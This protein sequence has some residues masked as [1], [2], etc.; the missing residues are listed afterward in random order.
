MNNSEYLNWMQKEL[1]RSKRWRS[2]GE[3][4]YE[5]SWKRFIDL[6]RG[7]HYDRKSG[8]DQL[9][10]NMIFATLNVMAPAVAIRNPKFNVNARNVDSAP[11]AIITEEVL[12][13][14][15][16][17]NHFQQDFRLS[18]NDWLTIGHGWL[19]VGYTFQKPPEEKKTEPPTDTAQD[20]DG[21]DEG[22]DD[23]EDVPGNVETEL[24]VQQ[25]DE[26]PFM[27]RISPFDMFVD[28][29]CR[30]PKEM[31]W[32]AQR[33]WRPVQ[34]VKV[35]SRYVAAARKNVSGTSRSSRD[36]GNESGGGD[37]RDSGEKPDAGAL[38]Y[39]EV[40]EFYDIKRNKVSTF[41][42]F[43]TE[44]TSKEAFL[45]KPTKMP[46]AFGHPFVMLRNYEVPDHFY[47]MGDVQQIESLQIELNETRNQMFNFRKKYRRA[48][49]YSKDLFDREGVQALESDEDNVMIPVLGDGNPS[50][51]LAPVV[52]SITPPEFFDQSAM[53]SNDIDRISGV[54]DYQ[55]G[56][57]TS[58]KRTATEA[59]M[60]QDAANARAQDRLGKVETILA[61]CGERI[62]ALMQQYVTGDQVARIVT[63]PVRGWINYNNDKIQGK[64]DFEV[65]GGSTEPQNEST[66]RQAA[67]QAVDM[68]V[69]FM[70]EGVVNTPA[71]YMK[72]LR[73]GLGFKDAER[74]V[75]MQEPQ[76]PPP[77]MDQQGQKQGMHEMPDGSMMPDSEMQQGPPQGMPPQGMPPQGGP[78]AAINPEMLAMLQQ[79]LGGQAPPVG[80]GA[81]G[82]PPELLQ[83]MM[84]AGQ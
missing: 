11:Q 16:R 77:G 1:K 53:I 27:E 83:Q 67:L 64:F 56:A 61:Q 12:N 34:D 62:V 40:I 47:P 48:H 26:R 39:V 4:N 21:A 50:S 25:D 57:Q 75:K 82:I 5:R 46:Y 68:S 24:I 6:Y 32:V 84:Q 10:V 2:N 33:T 81:S 44:D 20:G 58:I 9:T 69:P 49:L 72:L 41:S 73:D 52:P 80:G 8:T 79:S 22:V 29:D 55:R 78:G 59:G 35:D 13:Y 37:G 7:Q 71:L 76:A 63:I 60:I 31:R 66:R 54:S 14:I 43:R 23:R 74:Y 45:I 19:K 18:I 36:V 65:V 70:G 28:P 42:V 30:H 3:Q 38:S 17:S 51:A 15:W